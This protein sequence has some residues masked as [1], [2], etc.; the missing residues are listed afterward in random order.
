MWLE[1]ESIEYALSLIN[2][3]KLWVSISSNM[4]KNAE[5]IKKQ[6]ALII[7]RRNKIAHES[8]RDYLSV[9][10][11]PIDKPLVDGTIEFLDKFCESIA[12]LL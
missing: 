10:K 9:G 3:G 6:L 5:D 11:N 2:I 12:K 1:Q 4:Q 8:D 7:D